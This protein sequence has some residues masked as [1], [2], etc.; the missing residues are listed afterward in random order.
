M[1]SHEGGHVRTR[2]HHLTSG[3][4]LP[5]N[6]RRL[7][8]PL[9]K[10]LARSLEVPTTG[11]LSDVRQ[12]V[13]GKIEEMGHDPR[14]T[15]I[16]VYDGPCG[17]SLSL[18][19]ADGVFQ[20]VEP[21]DSEGVEGGGGATSQNSG[22]E[23]GPQEAER[24]LEA[25][26]TELAAVK[27][28]L[29]KEREAR[30]RLWTLNCAQVRECDGA[31]LEKDE[32]IAQLREQVL[33]LQRP[34]STTPSQPQELLRQE[35][36]RD[37]PR[38]RKGKAPPV[39]LFSGEDPEVRFD[40]WLPTLERAAQWNGWTMEERSMQLAGYLKGRALQEWGLLRAADRETYD[41][42]ASALRSRLDPG[43]KT[44]AAQD[45]RHCSQ[46]EAE[47][48]CDFIRRLERSFRLA[49]GSRRYA[50]RNQR[51]PALRPA[52]RGAQ[53]PTDGSTRCIRRSE[54]PVPVCSR[55]V[56]GAQAGRVEEAP[57]V[58]A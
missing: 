37:R 35:E 2:E 45:F 31:L 17:P 57:A 10:Q 48:V 24:E 39:A 18:R 54:L 12:L 28:D 32:E 40:D 58:Q 36:V 38:Q 26:R 15:Q 16:V 46:E 50:A 8:A 1:S 4:T 33:Q 20:E 43:S 44:M 56:R 13:E 30:G 51:C 53:V 25:L 49:Y 22:D 5:L 9:V 29:R 7:T 6:L 55:E 47:K 52:P 21:T 14:N 42:V 23:G 19:D 41:Q 27:E 34:G 11:P 3:R